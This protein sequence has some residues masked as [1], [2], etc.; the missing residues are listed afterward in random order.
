VKRAASSKSQ[1]ASKSFPLG[2]C[3]LEPATCDMEP[4][5]VEGDNVN[6]GIMAELEKEGL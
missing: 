4:A 5:T 2:T 6:I 3:G 1:V